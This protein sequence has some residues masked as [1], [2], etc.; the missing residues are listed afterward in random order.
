MAEDTN[1][2]TGGESADRE[3]KSWDWDAA[4]PQA[5][6]DSFD[7]G[8]FLTESK[9]DETA[10]EPLN[11]TE[12]DPQSAEAAETVTDNSAQEAH[13]E[14]KP[15]TCLI[16][17][18]N[19]RKSPSE[20][21]CNDCREKY[22]KVSFGASHIILSIVMVFAAVFGI[23]LF[24]TTGQIVSCV[25]KGDAEL[26]QNLISNAS[27]SY[28]AVADKVSSLNDGL[29]AFLQGI[30]T[31]F[32]T[33]TFF[34][35]GTQVNKD[36]ARLAIKTV[37]S[38]YTDREYFITLVESTF[39]EDE[40]NK[41]ENAD[42]KECYEFCKSMD[43]TANDMY[44][45]WYAML[46]ELMNAYDEDGKLVDKDAPT[47]KDILAHLD[48]Y[49]KANP[50]AEKSTVDYY[51]FMTLYYQY[52]YFDNADKDEMLSYLQS[53]YNE[54][55]KYGYF[56]ADNYMGFAWEC[57]KYDELL[58]I[59][60]ATYELNPSNQNAFYF[61]A[62]VNVINGDYDAAVDVCNTLKK[63]NPDSLEY[64]TIQAEVLRRK[65]DFTAA[66]DICAQGK[67]QGTDPELLRQESIIY[68][69]NG[70]KD[71]AL[72]SAKDAYEATVSA[73]Y[74]SDDGS[75]SI[76]ILNTTALICKLCG[77]DATY[78]EIKS[79]MSSDNYD[80]ED[81]VKKVISGDT[82][83]EELFMSGKGDI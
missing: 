39:D 83:F 17:G 34:D 15:G 13:E 66:L 60:K 64:Y 20:L 75:V 32:K 56:Y 54:A 43:D 40:L 16:C 62:K 9:A 46:D 50:D 1:K 42:I 35:S 12:E 71:K 82:T 78:D 21:Y 48:E 44:E 26:K 67:D 80:L 19:L 72:D 18:K 61:A 76:E 45:D 3:E 59:A 52:V 49:Q 24:S 69:L 58:K 77:D 36:L 79:M 31:N 55:G 68:M 81:S 4:A 14:H 2:K 22:L 29:N 47:A 51:R 38:S 28:N 53:A 63:Y 74:S 8:E 70:E 30:S 41:K 27:D 7:I 57:E 11:E 5:P 23:V 25:R 37:S 65:G 73:S 6:T 10:A 33:V